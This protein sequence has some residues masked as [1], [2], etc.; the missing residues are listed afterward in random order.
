MRYR[1]RKK[2]THTEKV[3]NK[4]VFDLV[5]DDVISD[6]QNDKC[7]I[8]LNYGFEGFGKDVN[9]GDTILK[10]VSVGIY[11]IYSNYTK[12]HKTI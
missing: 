2:K 10:K 4:S 5:S 1:C 7:K 8:L 3:H 11:I 6:C 12:Y 9:G